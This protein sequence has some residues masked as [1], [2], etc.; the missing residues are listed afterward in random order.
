MWRVVHRVVVVTDPPVAAVSTRGEAA[1]GIRRPPRRVVR[2]GR[3]GRLLRTRGGSRRSRADP[4]RTCAD[5]GAGR[6]DMLRYQVSVT[7]TEPVVTRQFPAMGS[8][9][10]L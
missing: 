1:R 9:A 10:E 3:V 2:A 4:P 7:A 5:A 8:T 6:A